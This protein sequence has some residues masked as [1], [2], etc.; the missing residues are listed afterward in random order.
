MTSPTSNRGGTTVDRDGIGALG[1]RV[2]FDRIEK[3]TGPVIVTTNTDV[4]QWWRFFPTKAMGMAFSDRV[5]GGATGIKFTGPSIR[6]E[7]KKRK[8]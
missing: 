6:H 7:P 4:K 3:Q 1:A 2:V 5:L 8:K